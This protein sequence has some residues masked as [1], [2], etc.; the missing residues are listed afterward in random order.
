MEQIHGYKMVYWISELAKYLPS[1]GQI[2]END[3]AYVFFCIK[4]MFV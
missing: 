4:L 2:F 1:Y 3:F